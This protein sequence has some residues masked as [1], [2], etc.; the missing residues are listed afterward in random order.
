MTLQQC[1][2]CKRPY[3]PEE[4]K[5]AGRHL[6]CG[7]RPAGEMTGKIEGTCRIIGELGRG[8]TGVVYLAQ[9]LRLQRRAA[10]KLMTGN[11]LDNEKAANLFFSEVRAAGKL[12]H[13][14]IARIYTAGE[15]DRQTPYSVMEYVEGRT[16]E[17]HLAKQKKFPPLEV[18]RIALQIADALQYAWRTAELSHGDLKPANI[19]L[20]Q[21]DQ[22]VCIL[23]M[24]L[25]AARKENK[26]T[27]AIGTPLYAAPELVNRDFGENDFRADIYSLGIMM[28]EML[29]GAAPFDGT[30]AEI[31]RLHQ[32][33]DAPPV[34]KQV[35]EVPAKL[36]DLIS[37]MLLRYAQDRPTWVQTFRELKEIIKEMDPSLRPAP[38]P[39][40]TTSPHKQNPGRILALF[41][42]GI[43][44]SGLT[45]YT[46]ARKFPAA[47]APLKQPADRPVA[48]W[49][50]QQ[51]FRLAE[52]G[53]TGELEQ[54]IRAGLPVD[55]ENAR[56]NTLLM[57]A[58][59]FGRE[60]TVR[61]LLRYDP[62]LNHRNQL[63]ENVF[64]I[65][66]LFPEIHELLLQQDA[67]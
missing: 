46:F 11:T 36:D 25:Q 7:V 49:Q 6:C 31:V 13:P 22:S 52:L 45:G 48:D 26:V 58:V 63:G 27:S 43:L 62:E 40:A 57:Q 44:L 16:L 54:L 59:Y 47:P 21:D 56:G 28:Y 51:A 20:R 24:G 30:P 29:A 53:K 66:R 61:M 9:Q 1:E 60:D 14:N 37:R 64:D 35:P 34:R 23:D 19:M 65:A 8:A 18:C 32:T 38:P 55:I 3:D 50:K 41:L 17:E 2:F 10:L 33:E 67:G 12:I 15:T 5:D 39:P 4:V 42:L